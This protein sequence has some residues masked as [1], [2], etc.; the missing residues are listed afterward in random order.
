MKL[1]YAPGTC[2]LACWISL[3]WAGADYSV[4]KVKLGSPDYLKINPLGMVPAVQLETNEILTQA[5]AILQHIARQ[6]PEKDLAG[7]SD[8]LS[9]FR[10]NEIMDFLSADFH[11]AFWPMFSP[12][13]YTTSKDPDNIEQTLQSSY[14]LIDK[15]MTYLDGLIGDTNH[16]YKNKRTVADAYAYV[17]ALWAKKTPKSYDQYPNISRFMAEMEKD[18]AVQKV[19]KASK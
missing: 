15:V 14:I 4:E 18:S 7:D 16:V 8:A 17:M 6:Y 9:E 3:E 10:F 5:G 1:F 19:L 13:R 12:N 11:P 2:A